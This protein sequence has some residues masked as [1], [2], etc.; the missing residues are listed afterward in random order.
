MINYFWVSIKGKN[1]KK[2][3]GTFIKQKINMEQI[4]YNK[5]EILVK[6]SYEDYKKIKGIRTSYKVDIVKT[7]GKNRL[8]SLIIVNLRKI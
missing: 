8:L 7:S 5:D 1:P 6:V 2:L 4:K 3:L